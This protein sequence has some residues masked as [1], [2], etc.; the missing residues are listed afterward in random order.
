MRAV[1]RGEC[2]SKGRVQA[3]GVRRSGGYEEEEEEGGGGECASREG[4]GRRMAAE[5]PIVE[6]ALIFRWLEFPLMY[7]NILNP[8]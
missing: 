4:W 1:I 5:A 2:K 7:E 3:G 6:F 8:Q